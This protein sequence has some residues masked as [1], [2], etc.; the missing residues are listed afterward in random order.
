M[1]FCVHF[2]I[3]HF[4]GLQ[5]EMIHGGPQPNTHVLSSAAPTPHD[6]ALNALYLEN[7]QHTMET[8]AD[9]KTRESVLVR[10][11]KLL[12]DW[13]RQEA[14]DKGWG[15]IIAAEAG[16][17]IF[18]SG[19]YRMGVHGTG[20]DIDVILVAPRFITSADFFE[21]FYTVLCG[22]KEITEI[23]RTP[24]ARQPIISL[25]FQGIDLDLQLA[26]LNLNSIDR[27]IDIFDPTILRGLDPTTIRTLSGPSVADKVLRFVPKIQTFRECL[28]GVKAWARAR[29]IYSS[30]MSY[31]GGVALAVLVARVCQLYP[32]AASFT[33]LGKFFTM[34][35]N[36]FSPKPEVRKNQ[37]IYLTVDLNVADSE[38]QQL[39]WDSSKKARDAT[40]I[41]PVITPAL[42]YQNT[43]AQVT[44]SSMRVICEEF[45]RGNAILK[46]VTR[47]C[48]GS[49]NP[50]PEHFK[51]GFQALFA[52]TEFFV[53]FTYFLRV[54]V[55]V[56]DKEIFESYSSA[57]ESRLGVLLR[58]MER[59]NPDVACHLFPRCFH[60]MATKDVACETESS[61]FIGIDGDFAS[62]QVDLRQ[63]VQEFKEAISFM[64]KNS[65]YPLEKVNEPKL[66]V[67]KG[68][69]LP[70]VVITAEQKA[71]LEK[72]RKTF[73]EMQKAL[74][75]KGPLVK[76]SRTAAEAAASLQMQAAAHLTNVSKKAEETLD[77]D[78]GLKRTRPDDNVGES[79]APNA[80]KRAVEQ[81]ENSDD[82]DADALADVLAMVHGE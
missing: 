37:P 33:L 11:D 58:G 59:C 5:N 49:D 68:S 30:R 70:T 38:L 51:E 82:D 24:S 77:N 27:K 2:P 64:M 81:E 79:N 31:M 26:A 12:K 72:Q 44:K 21:R 39:S 73:A 61:F 71:E 10:V 62:G 55:S 41:F 9:A 42:P 35:A 32:N 25:T 78:V 6:A 19:S 17:R 29:G 13:I 1:P 56:K 43:C 63:G 36:W 65:N 45:A 34:Y 15:S 18:T 8:A 74:E 3:L 46:Y 57:V 7:I 69:D 76:P 48:E 28:R 47:M 66:Q 50:S 80:K 60:V 53:K 52:P 4:P 14:I 40:H 75:R 67:V 54:S 16:G 22:V 20:D 23:H